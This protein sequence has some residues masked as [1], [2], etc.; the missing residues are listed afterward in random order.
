[1]GEGYLIR[2]QFEKT[3]VLPSSFFLEQR[4]RGLEEAIYLLLQWAQKSMKEN[5]VTDAINFG[6]DTVDH[7]KDPLSPNYGVRHIRIR[8]GEILNES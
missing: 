2:Y 1:M 3:I 6:I 5:G 8:F 4:W 7:L